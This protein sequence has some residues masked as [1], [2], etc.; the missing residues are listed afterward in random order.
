[1]ELR[2]L[3]RKPFIVY[4]PGTIDKLVGG[5]I[6]TPAQVYDPFITSEV[7]TVFLI[8]DLFKEKDIKRNCK[9]N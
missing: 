3:L 5:L 9:T 6:N 8:F 7:S 4:Q 1:M 2:D